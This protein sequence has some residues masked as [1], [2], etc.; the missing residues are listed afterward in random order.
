ML[1]Y[2]GSPTQMIQAFE[3]VFKMIV[4]DPMSD[5]CPNISY[6]DFVGP[7]VVSNDFMGPPVPP[8][9]IPN[10]ANPVFLGAM[11]PTPQLC[12]EALRSALRNSGY[13]FPSSDEITA[14]VCTLANYGFLGVTVGPPRNNNMSLEEM[15][16][17]LG[18]NRFPAE[19]FGFKPAS[20]VCSP[21]DG[22]MANVAM[23]WGSNPRG[24]GNALAF[25]AAAPS[26]SMSQD[27]FHEV[28]KELQV[29]ENIVGAILGQGGR[30]I[31]EIQKQTLTTIHISKKGVFAPGTHNRIVTIK[32]SADA[33][34]KAMFKI[35][36]CIEYEENKRKHEQM[37]K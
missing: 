25:A 3:L 12:T 37:L 13:S 28:G 36:Q 1:L 6:S 24:D 9:V 32:G 5:S 30:G 20:G 8:T 7:P 19:P 34:E 4:E 18:G 35:K 17:V 22:S 29:G 27:N 10:F 26:F 15:V 14:A 23:G 33:V 21:F 16:A 2:A 31:V 11:R